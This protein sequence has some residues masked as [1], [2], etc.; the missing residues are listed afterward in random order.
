MATADQW[1]SLVGERRAPRRGVV[2]PPAVPGLAAWSTRAMATLLE[3]SIAASIMSIY[4]VAL[5]W[6]RPVFALVQAVALL[7]GYQMSPMF[8]FFYWALPVLFLVWQ[9]AERGRTGQS[10]G[11][12]LM[13]IVTVD[14]DTG[15]PIGPARSVMR[16]VLHL[17]DIAPLFFGFLWPLAHYR[18]QTF[19]DQ[20]SR[21]LVV[22][23]SV[24]NQIAIAKEGTS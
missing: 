9:A 5:Y 22:D 23:V 19:A 13:R 1:R 14:E 8:R 6:A 15:A 11:Q 18:K 16:S 7:T 24:I 17:V 12:R 4:E 10:L 21:S 20:L 3:L 2:R